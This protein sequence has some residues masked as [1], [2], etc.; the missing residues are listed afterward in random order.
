MT[1]MIMIMMNMILM[2]IMIMKMMNMIIM[3]LMMMLKNFMCLITC[4][5]L[6]VDQLSP[7]YRSI[8]PMLRI[9]SCKIFSKFL[10]ICMKDR[11]IIKGIDMIDDRYDGRKNDR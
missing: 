5:S 11:F 3:I 8:Q 1:I 7:L 10:L 6:I 4:F 2:I 9:N